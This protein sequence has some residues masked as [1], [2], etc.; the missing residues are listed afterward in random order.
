V[1]LASIVVMSAALIAQQPSLSQARQ[2]YYDT[3]YEEAL[4]VLDD[5]AFATATTSDRQ[6]AREYRALA[7]FALHRV[8]EAQ[9]IIDEMVETDPFYR[10]SEAMVPPGVLMAF[11][12]AR[13]QRIPSLVREA[14]GQAIVNFEAKRYVEAADGFDR[15]LRLIRETGG[16]SGDPPTQQ[17]REVKDLAAKFVMVSRAARDAKTDVS[18]KTVFSASDAG[19]TPPVAIRHDVPAWRPENPDSGPFEGQLEVVVDTDGNVQSAKLT[20]PVNPS[21][22]PVLLNA[23]RTWKYRPASKDG[24]PIVFK[25]TVAIYLV[26]QR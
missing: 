16:K 19:V 20:A 14:Y 23:A 7:L 22:D 8:S 2:L 9:A 21:Y 26:P 15:V 13:Q 18:V 10:P 12:R 1:V 6:I 3:Y 24:R 4:D 5:A 17:L 25:E 11:D